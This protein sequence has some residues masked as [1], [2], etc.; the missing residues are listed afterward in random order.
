MLCLPV[1][2]NNPTMAA[3]TSGIITLIMFYLSSYSALLPVA[4]FVSLTV[5]FIIYSMM[6]G[7]I[8]CDN[9]TSSTTNDDYLN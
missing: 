4:V 2:I 1:L 9:P 7:K 5:S 8:T 3:L 6:G